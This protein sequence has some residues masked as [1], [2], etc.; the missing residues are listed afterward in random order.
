MLHYREFQGCKEYK[1]VVSP[2]VINEDVPSPAVGDIYIDTQNFRLFYFNTNSEW[3]E[4]T[5][6]SKTV[7]HP[8]GE[9]RFL[10]PNKRHFSWKELGSWCKIESMVEIPAQ[11]HIQA[12]V[13]AES[14]R[15]LRTAKATER[16]KRNYKKVKDDP[17]SS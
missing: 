17:E 13:E 8:G 10:A 3:N 14:Q 15:N 5:A 7:T 1:G 4:W 12:V 16:R 11:Q 2:P 6:L 9:K